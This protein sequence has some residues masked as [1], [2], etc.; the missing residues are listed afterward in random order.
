MSPNVKKEGAGIM[1]FGARVDGTQL[2]Q[3]RSVP[4][5]LYF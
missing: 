3:R 2:M 1:A 5:A 4:A